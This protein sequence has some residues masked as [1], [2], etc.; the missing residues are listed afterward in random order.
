VNTRRCSLIATAWMALSVGGCAVGNGSGEAIGPL[1][2]LNCRAEEPRDFGTPAAPEEFNLQPTFF[3]GEPIE[4]ISDGAP[5]NRLIIRMQRNSIALEINDVLYFD[6]PNSFEVAQCLRGQTIGGVGQ[7]N[8]SSGT[9]DDNDPNTPP[10]P[11][12]CEQNGPNGLPRIH[13]VPYGPVRAA[14]TPFATCRS[15]QHGPTVVAITGVA[16]D[17]WIDFEYFGQAEQLDL[18]PEMRTP[19]EDDFK[20]NF[21]ERLRAFFHVDLDDNR[22][23][24]AIRKMID[25]PPDPVIGGSLDGSF[26][27]D[28]ERGGSAQ[29]FP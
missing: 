15:S 24:T 3:A 5:D 12:W 9:L 2:I 25:V 11:P 19:V 22:V 10:A 21:G 29:T 4:D 17:G 23:Q 6:I 16:F 18:A 8:M 27:F 7:W 20:V 13:L 14:L 26:D 1:W 28:M